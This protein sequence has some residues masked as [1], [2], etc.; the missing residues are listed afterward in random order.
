MTSE[1]ERVEASDSDEAG[2]ADD[3]GFGGFEEADPD[4]DADGADGLDNDEE[5]R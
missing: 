2:E 3:W 5:R 4:P 1:N